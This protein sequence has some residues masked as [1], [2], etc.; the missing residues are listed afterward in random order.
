MYTHTHTHTHTHTNT[1]F[2]SLSHTHTRHSLSLFL[3]LDTLSLLVLTF[4]YYRER[5]RETYALATVCVVYLLTLLLTP[6]SPSLDTP[7][8]SHTH[9]PSLDTPSPSLSLTRWQRLCVENLLNLVLTLLR[10][11]DFALLVLTLLYYT[12]RDR[13]LRVGNGV[14]GIFTTALAL[15]WCPVGIFFFL[16]SNE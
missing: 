12:E 3:T 10:S 15:S 16:H 11:T 6:L 14:R 2:L 13:D 5:E 1:H 4:L 9:A 8:L 7:S